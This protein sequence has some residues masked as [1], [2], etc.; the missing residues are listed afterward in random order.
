M[1]EA[2]E[3]RQLLPDGPTIKIK[4]LKPGVKNLN[5]SFIIVSKGQIK[6]VTNGS[7]VC[8]FQ[9]ADETGSVNLSLWNDAADFFVPGD[10]CSLKSGSTSVH[11]GVMSL[12]LGRHSEILKTGRI[13]YDFSIKPDM[14]AYNSEYEAKFPLSK[15]PSASD[16]HDDSHNGNR[17]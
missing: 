13:V 16:S 10:I 14:S 6:Q 1:L 8:N 9:V 11:K 7:R 3:P 4:E 12:T 5:L 15:G 17:T 2:Y